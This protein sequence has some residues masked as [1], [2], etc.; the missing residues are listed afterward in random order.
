MNSLVNASEL[1]TETLSFLPYLFYI[2]LPLPYNSPFLHGILLPSAQE[3]SLADPS[4]I[5]PVPLSCFK[6]YSISS[7]NPLW[8]ELPKIPLSTHFLTS[9]RYSPLF[10]KHTSPLSP[11][12][13]ISFSQLLLGPQSPEPK[14]SPLSAH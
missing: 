11:C 7:Q 6:A 1:V 9:Q 2:S 13:L 5:T 8:P 10:P 14:L 12:I 3:P 4:E